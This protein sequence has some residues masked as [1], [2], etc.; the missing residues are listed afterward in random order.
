MEA[1]AVGVPF[2]HDLDERLVHHV[3]LFLAVFILEVLLLAA[4]DGRKFRQIV[5]HFPVEGDIGKRRLRAPA[6]GGVHA[7]DKALDALFHL[8][9]REVVRLYEGREIGIEGGERLRARPFVLHDAE[10]VDHLVA[11]RG[12]VLCGCGRDLP[13][14]AAQPFLDELF[15]R[16]ARAIARQ[17]GQIVDMDVRVAVRLGDFVVID[18]REPVVGG[19][20]A[21]VGEDEPAHRIG[22]GGVLFHTPVGRLHIAVDELFIVEHR[23]LHVADLLPLFAVEDV[24][25]G[26]VRI[27]RLDEHALHAVLDVLDGDLVVFDLRL[28]IR[29]HLQREHID[30]ARVILLCLRVERLGDRLG[31]LL[32]VELGDLAVSLDDP[33]HTV[34]FFPRAQRRPLPV[35]FHYS[36]LFCKC[37]YIGAKKFRETQYIVCSTKSTNHDKLCGNAPAAADFCN[38]RAVGALF[39]VCGEVLMPARAAVCGGRKIFQPCSPRIFAFGI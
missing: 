6:G 24:A 33:V 3:H 38:I 13:R 4:D 29:R 17:H 9:V 37:Q 27:S 35:G 32:D 19:D 22:D 36:T 21:A 20:R 23:R 5:G 8:V 7:V 15:E 1:P 28:E 31:D 11:K 18:L 26:D 12:K 25:L 14:D 39:V 10:E 16:P 34:S 2:D 30:D